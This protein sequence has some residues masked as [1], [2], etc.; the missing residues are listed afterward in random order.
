MG[1]LAGIVFF[2]SLLNTGLYLCFDKWKWIDY[3]EAY[4]PKWMPCPGFCVFF[5]A[6]LIELGITLFT[7]PPFDVVNILFI[8]SLALCSAVLSRYFVSRCG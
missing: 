5:W 1:T 2:F 6:A 3:Y 4:K 8:F 7:Y